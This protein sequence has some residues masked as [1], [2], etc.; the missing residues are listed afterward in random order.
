[1]P[2]DI[3][4]LLVLIPALPLLAAVVTAVAG[5]QLLRSASHW[6]A[7]V[8]VAAAAVASLL[9]VLALK[10]EPRHERIVTLWTWSAVSAAEGLPAPASSTAGRAG[11]GA[12][13]PQP[14]AGGRQPPQNPGGISASTL[15]CGP[16]R[17]RPSCSLP[18]PSSASW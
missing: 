3:P 18:S 8:A 9:L 15:P 7:I 11:S 6:P 17:S 5:K 2:L 12:L 16:I 10:H 1:M 4:T 14:L 13:T